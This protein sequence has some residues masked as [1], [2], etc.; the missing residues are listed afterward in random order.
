MPKSVKHADIPQHYLKK[1]N[2]LEEESL[3]GKKVFK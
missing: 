1:T 2:G 3:G